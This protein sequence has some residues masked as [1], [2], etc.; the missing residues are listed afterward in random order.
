MFRELLSHTLVYFLGF[1][2]DTPSSIILLYYVWVLYNL[3]GKIILFTTDTC[4]QSLELLASSL[5]WL[6]EQCH[7]FFFL[8]HSLFTL[9]FSG[10]EDGKQNSVSQKVSW[11]RLV[12][13]NRL[14]F[15]WNL[16]PDKWEQPALL[17]PNSSSQSS[18]HHALTHPSFEAATSNFKSKAENIP[19]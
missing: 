6:S 4:Y 14:V 10:T 17:C 9:R 5:T 13:T 12:V 7:F 3:E 11:F 2:R 19:F 8:L 15:G 16:R 1:T 18:T